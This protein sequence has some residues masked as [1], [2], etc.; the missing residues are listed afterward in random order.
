MMS[1]DMWLGDD[2]VTVEYNFLE[3]DESV[4]LRDDFEFW[5]FLDDKEISQ[6]LTWEQSKEVYKA[7][8]ENYERQDFDLYD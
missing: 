6:D 8:Q 5:V 4:G 3:G 7:C 1:F 2:E